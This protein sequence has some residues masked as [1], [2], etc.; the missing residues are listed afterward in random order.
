MGTAKNVVMVVLALAV[1]VLARAVIRLENYRYA[2]AVGFCR[3]YTTKDPLQ[4]VQRDRSLEN[5][6]TRTNGLWHLFYALTD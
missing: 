6:Q 1:F 2:N 3:E 4:L 5:T